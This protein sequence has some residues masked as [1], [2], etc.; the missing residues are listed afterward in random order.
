M[1][2][3]TNTTMMALQHRLMLTIASIAQ[4]VD[5]DLMLVVLGMARPLKMVVMD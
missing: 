4:Q 5:T 3:E 2:M 1:Q